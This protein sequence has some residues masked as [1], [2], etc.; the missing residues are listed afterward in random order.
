M[1]SIAINKPVVPII[2]NAWQQDFR[3]AE[4][5]GEFLFDQYIIPIFVSLL[6]DNDSFLSGFRQ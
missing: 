4:F 5:N 1:N 3:L 2:W 6:D